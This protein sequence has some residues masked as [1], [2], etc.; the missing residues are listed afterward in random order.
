MPGDAILMAAGV[1]T[2]VQSQGGLAQ[3]ALIDR[4]LTVRGGYT[5]G[6]SVSDPQANPTV[7]DARQLG[8]VLVITGAVTVTV[9]GLRVTGGSAGGL[10]GSDAGAGVNAYS[11]TVS[12]SGT[13]VY[14]NAIHGAT[15]LGGVY[16]WGGRVA[17]E[18][19][20]ITFNRLSQPGTSGDPRGGGVAAEDCRLTLRNSRIAYNT[21]HQV[22]GSGRDRG[23]GGGVY[24]SGQSA[25]IDGNTVEHNTSTDIQYHDLGFRGS[26][27]GV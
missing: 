9:E 23:M 24:I 2:D 19:D 6:W 26:G 13:A 16:A 3:L 18:N 25:D 14:S 12:L 5:T 15:P 17:L 1:Y 22:T 11:A 10:D 4:S 27:G 20:D 7:L 21:A 8:R